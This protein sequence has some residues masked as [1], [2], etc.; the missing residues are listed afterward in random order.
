MPGPTSLAGSY[1]TS[2]SSHGGGTWH[3]R[4]EPS[5]KYAGG[6]DRK[7]YEDFVFDM[8][9]V[10]RSYPSHVP[11]SS[12]VAVLAGM[13]VGDALTYFNSKEYYNSDWQ[14]VCEELQARFLPL[15]T[16]EITWHKFWKV[17]QYDTSSRQERPI[18]EVIQ[19]LEG[20]QLRLGSSCSS[21]IMLNRLW[22][23]FSDGMRMAMLQV[24]ADTYD[25][26]REN[27]LQTDQRRRQIQE[28]KAERTTQPAPTRERPPTD[29]Q[30]KR[31]W[32]AS[33]V[34]AS[35][36]NVRSP[37]SNERRP[38][39]TGATNNRGTKLTADELA[40]HLRDGLCFG[41]SQSGHSKV[42]CPEQASAS[43]SH[44]QVHH[45]LDEDIGEDGEGAEAHG[46]SLV[47][48]PGAKPRERPG[49]RALPLKLM[50]RIGG[51]LAYT[52][53]DDG[54]THNLIKPSFVKLHQLP[55]NTYRDPLTIK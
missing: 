52:L 2:R 10:F 18:T 32:T 50:I 44:S 53:V 51:K 39:R 55:Y 43:S 9:R 48:K 14:T 16:P 4:I 36:S 33:H 34:M 7:K 41:C 13:L 23:T 17:M 6:P 42:N 54:C 21:E 45:I 1:G 15:A 49:P 31:T 27:A 8:Q 25:E 3:P 30:K 47:D 46:V 40:Q 12:K 38:F 28:N 20:L 37:S 5:V 22:G 19:E 26:L 24:R 35:A 11:E 29:S